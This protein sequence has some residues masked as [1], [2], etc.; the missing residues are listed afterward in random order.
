MTALV[1]PSGAGKS[2]FVDL[3]PRMRD[4]SEGQI[5]LDGIPIQEFSTKS[6][7]AGIAFVPQQAQI[8]EG[9][10]AD[11]IRYGKPD[12][13]DEE[14]REAARIA[15]ALSFIE[16][17]PEGFNTQLR[18]GARRL[19]GGQRQRLDIARALNRG[20]PILILDEP[21]SALDALSEGAFRE[22]LRDL[23]EK[24][25]RT[26]IVI[27]HRM[28]TIADADQIVVFSHGQIEAVGTH[29]ELLARGSWYATAWSHQALPGGLE[30]PA[31]TS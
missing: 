24:T 18:D 15:G 26:I 27:A 30:Q 8:M 29:E 13:T 2:S 7:R 4:P 1:G 12:S 25:N 9:T 23:R 11:H 19:S 3:L 17:L 16:T 5:L 10:V 20:A 6:V 31:L 21:T 14:I 22:V 28:S